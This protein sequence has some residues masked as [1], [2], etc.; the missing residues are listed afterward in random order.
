MRPGGDGQFDFC[1]RR[2]AAPDFESRA[3]SSGPLA[4]ARQLHWF[5]AHPS[6]EV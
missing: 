6:V 5:F 1:S 3:D 2:G 4:Q